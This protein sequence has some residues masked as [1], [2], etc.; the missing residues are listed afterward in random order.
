[1]ERDEIK[2]VIETINPKI[3]IPVHTE[4]A[5]EFEKLHENVIIPEKGREIVL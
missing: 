2:E 4:N 3:L 1:M 5:T